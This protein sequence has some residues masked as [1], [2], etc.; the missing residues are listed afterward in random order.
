MQ[1]PM[2]GLF[3][4]AEYLLRLPD[5]KDF[6]FRGATIQAEPFNP[7]LLDAQ[8][9]LCAFLGSLSTSFYR[10]SPSYKPYWF[11][12][13]VWL[14]LGVDQCCPY[15][16][17][18]K[19]NF[20]KRIAIVHDTLSGDGYFGPNQKDAYTYG[21]KVNDHFLFVSKASHT[22]F[23]LWCR[24]HYLNVGNKQGTDYGNWHNFSSDN[25]NSP[26]SILRSSQGITVG[27]L[28][29]RKHVEAAIQL[30]ARYRLRKHKHLGN[31]GDL[32][33]PSASINRQWPQPVNPAKDFNFAGDAAKIDAIKIQRTVSEWIRNPSDALIHRELRK[34]MVFYCLSEA[35]GFSITPLEAMLTG[36]PYIIISDIPVHREIYDCY[37]SLNFVPRVM[38]DNEIL[39]PAFS[40]LK[41]L[42]EK[43][44]ED[45]YNRFLPE[46]VCQPFFDYLKSL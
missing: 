30:S 14:S 37:E 3:R 5:F 24:E 42:T 13:K 38:D 31:N 17:D 44:R 12:S 34:S 20:K 18:K 23:N 45:A 46:T 25:I 2:N 27:S 22:L 16:A 26:S 15:L 40:E 36:V 41:R 11:S 39:Y 19:F 8:R 4:H 6:C 32:F 33:D 9:K 7:Q 35:E 21:I 28:F 1:V 10:F 43:D 29:R